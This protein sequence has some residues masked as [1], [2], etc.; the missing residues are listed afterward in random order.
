MPR[1]PINYGNTDFYK[2]VCKD[3]SIP[4][5]YVGHT[6]NF[7]IR[8]NGHKTCCNNEASNNYH[9]HVYKFLRENGGWENWRIQKCLR[10]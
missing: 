7:R 1:K 9:Q 2:I 10:L 5:I 8:K 3:I 4:D 6:T